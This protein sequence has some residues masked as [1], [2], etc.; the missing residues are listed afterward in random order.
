MMPRIAA[1]AALAAQL[2]FAGAQPK[3]EPIR[4]SAWYWLNAAPREEWARDFSNMK[5][6]GFTDI[7]LCWGLDLTAWRFRVDDTKYALDLA[8]K[9]G[10]GA[11]MIVWHPTHNSLPRDPKFQQVD[12]AGNVRFTFDTFNPTWRNTQYKQYLQQVA[13]LYS[14]HPAFAGYIFDDTFGV[15]GIGGI[16]G[17]PA[18][19]AHDYI[20]YSASDI[21]LF[22]RQPPKSPTEQG[23]NEWVAARSEWWAAWSRDTMRFL[24]E[25]DSNPK[26]EI[27]LEDFIDSVFGPKVRDR[28]GLDFGKAAQPWDAVGAYTEPGWDESAGATQKQFD[29]TR[30]AIQK[31][32]A[33]VGPNKK[34]IYTFWSGNV[35]ELRTPGPA[36]YPT[37]PQI[38]EICEAA[39]SMGIRHLDMYGYR[40]GDYLVTSQNWAQKRAPESGPY[41]VTDPFPKK[42]LYDRTELHEDL[43]TYLLS[44][45]NR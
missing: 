40:I 43:R 4:I 3:P 2:A 38:R 1:V 10:L 9:S 20:S 39:L 19:P 24:R 6:L 12:A 21:K 26:H 23:W 7:S 30:A 8:S 36:K 44:L 29:L 18:D 14:S 5:R 37:V 22:G 15:G 28:V 13:K 42:Y 25:I 45:R 34:I 41:R 11:Y 32:R 17:K 27:Y 16:D 33:T 35:K 31:V